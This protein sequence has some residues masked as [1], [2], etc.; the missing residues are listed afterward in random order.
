MKVEKFGLAEL[1]RYETE[2]GFK[3]SDVRT[4]KGVCAIVDLPVTVVP[5]VQEIIAACNK[6]IILT[7]KRVVKI[8]AEDNQNDED[9]KRD[10]ERLKDA[11][12]ATKG[13]NKQAVAVAKSEAGNSN[14]EVAR[15]EKLLK[16]FS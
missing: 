12:V 14:G 16:N 5:E 3:K 1:E 2:V 13:K 4:I 7:E 11:R 15:L 8:K 6:D 10:I 9:T